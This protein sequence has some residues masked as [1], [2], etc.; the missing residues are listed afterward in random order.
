MV[1]R[2]LQGNLFNIICNKV[3][4]KLLYIYKGIVLRSHLYGLWSGANFYSNLRGRYWSAVWKGLLEQSQR[5]YSRNNQQKQLRINVVKWNVLD[6]YMLCWYSCAS[7]I[8]KNEHF[9]LSILWIMI[10]DVNFKPNCDSN[11]LYSS[12]VRKYMYNL[13]VLNC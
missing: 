11:V 10:L 5:V 12:K 9:L 7:K 4:K 1:S 6:I 8:C 13:T 3:N 2:V